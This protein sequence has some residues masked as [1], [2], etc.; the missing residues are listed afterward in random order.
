M[1]TTTNNNAINASGTE[2]GLNNIAQ[3]AS[4]VGMGVIMSMAAVVG[5]WGAACM[6]SGITQSGSLIEMARGYMTAL[7]M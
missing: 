3:G 4:E 1:N 5:V 6:I 7:G 2:T